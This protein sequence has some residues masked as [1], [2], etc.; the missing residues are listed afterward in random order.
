MFV[1]CVSSRNSNFQ[2]DTLVTLSESTENVS[3]FEIICVQ[4][5]CKI[6]KQNFNFNEKLYQHIRNHEVLKFV[7]NFRFSINTVNLICEIEKTSF[8]SFKF[9]VSFAK[10]SKS[11]FEFATTSSV[12]SLKHSNFLLFSLEMKS[13]STKK[14][15]TCRHCKQTFSFKKMFRQHKQEQH[16]KKLIV[17]SHFSINA[18]KSTCESI[19]IS[20]INSSFFVSLVVQSNTLFL[21]ANLDIFNSNRFHQ[22]LEKK[23]F[24]E[25]VIFIQHFQYCQQLYCESKVLKWM[26][27]IFYDFVDIWFENQSNFIFLHDFNIVLTKTFFATSKNLILNTKTILQIDSSKATCRHCDEIFN[28][29]K[30]FRK[31]KSEQHSKQHVKNFRFENN[32]IKLLCT[33]E[34]KLVVMNSFVS[35]ELQIFI[36]TSKQ[37]FESILIFEII[38]SQKSIHFSVHTLETVSESKKNKS[39]QCFFISSKSS[40]QTFESEHREISVQEFSD[41]CSFFSNNIVNS[42][43]EI[44][45]KLIIISIAKISKLISKQNVEWRFRI[46]YL[47]TKLKTF[48]LNFSLNTFVI[49]SKIIKNVSNQEIACVRT[50]C[51]F[52]KQNFNFNKKFFE[53]INEHEILKRINTIKTTCEFENKSIDICSSFLHESLIFATSKNLTSNTKTFMQFDSSRWFNFQLR[54]FDSASKSMK[55]FSIQ[56][57]VCA[58]ICKRCKQNFNFNNKF[59]EHIR[60]H[61]VRKSVKSLNFRIFASEIA[62]KIKK[63]S[64]IVCLFVSFDSFIFFATSKSIFCFAS[65]SSKCS[66]FSIA[67]FNITSKSMKKLSINCSFTF[68]ISFSR[69]FVSKHQKS[70]LIIDDL[71]RMF[72]ENFKSFDLRQHHNRR[73]FSQ[74]F[75]FCQFDR[76]CSIF[77]KKFHLIIENLFEMFDEKFKK[78]IY[79]KIKTTCF[80]KHFQIKCKSSFISNLQ[81]IKSRRLIKILL[82][83]SWVTI[84][85]LFWI[86]LFDNIHTKWEHKKCANVKALISTK[87]Y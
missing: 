51:K 68:S 39:I 86:S 83:K 76:S 70:Y 40:F 62:Y 44:V 80:F 54:A 53:H 38:I 43:C 60:E 87:T 42:T 32:A 25:I 10:F 85:L 24:N 12:T 41:I 23:R 20:T 75:D 14:L 66:R 29:K 19:E 45:E 27:V 3:N 49:I 55:K 73:F 34:K 2:L 69:T 30:S 15:A 21:F 57:I 16:V 84:I 35:F 5:S 79:F 17:N 50:M 36:A 48:R 31:H 1:R 82:K 67:T 6:C 65:I 63:K 13:D 74:S 4:I 78:K 26:K 37:I 28:F 22:N 58:R 46:V 61:H 47:F 8:V 71:N 33:I 81:S 56:Q 72:V 9:L 64:T 7:K 77:S 18:I 52:C 11:I 59:H